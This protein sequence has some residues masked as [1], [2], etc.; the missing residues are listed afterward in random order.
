MKRN[1]AA[2][3]LFILIILAIIGLDGCNTRSPIKNET[4]KVHFID[5]DRDDCKLDVYTIDGCQYI[6]HLMGSDH[7]V[8][9]H[10]GN[11]TNPIHYSHKDSIK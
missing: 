9:T 4:F 7:D 11:C 2:I 5:T 8:L 10:K 6:G 3:I 1:I